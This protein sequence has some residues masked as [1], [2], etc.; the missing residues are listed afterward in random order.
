MTTQRFSRREA[1][2]STA[3][4][5][6]ASRVAVGG[7]D[8]P[9]PASAWSSRKRSSLVRGVR[10][11]WYETGSG[12]PIV[13]LHGNPTSS[14]LWRK[15]IPHVAG[16]GRCIAPDLVG[17]GDSAKLVPSSDAAYSFKAHSEYLYGLLDALGVDKNV[18]LVV[19]DWG[20]GLGF[21][22]ARMDPARVRGIAYMEAILRPTGPVDMGE[23]QGGYFDMLRSAKGEELVLQ[24]N[25]FV[26]QMLIGGLKY[27]LTDEDMAE[28]RRPYLEPGEGRRPTLTWPRELPLNGKPE[29]NDRIVQ[30]YTQWLAGSQIPKLFVHAVPGAIFRDPAMLALARSLP[31]QREVTV[32]GGHFVQEVSGDAIGRALADWIPSLK[33]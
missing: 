32:Y 18:I 9:P 29:V 21:E 22:W 3:A 30:E 1:L 11:A 8:A 17:M 10:M 23:T 16:L 14:Y 5:G 28:Y 20:S 26:D 6:L 15:V 19:H 13:F 24:K 27:Y 31:N 25:M 7:T 33:A 4:A 2:I 12:D